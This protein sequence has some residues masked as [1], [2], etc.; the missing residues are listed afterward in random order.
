[1]VHDMGNVYGYSWLLEVIYLLVVNVVTW[2]EAVARC[3]R[4][5]NVLSL[6][7]YLFGLLR[8]FGSLAPCRMGQVA[9]FFEAFASQHLFYLVMVVGSVNAP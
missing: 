3:C 6:V 4:H 7:T 2:V 9:L 1:M 8:S 5:I